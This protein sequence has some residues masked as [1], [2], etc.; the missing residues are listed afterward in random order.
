[1]SEDDQALCERVLQRVVEHELTARLGP[2]APLSVGPEAGLPPLVLLAARTIT[3]E[4]LQRRIRFLR[5]VGWLA[6]P[7]TPLP[8]PSLPAQA[9]L[10]D[11]VAAVLVSPAVK[12]DPDL[13]ALGDAYDGPDDGEIRR[14]D[15]FFDRVAD[16]VDPA[17]RQHVPGPPATSPAWSRLEA[18][19]MDADRWFGHRRTGRLWSSVASAAGW[20]GE[21]KRQRWR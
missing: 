10:E 9:S 15:A 19:T 11:R 12:S 2:S 5:I 6:E 3:P 13:I 20:L 18:A 16:A 14:L 21:E 17:W 8:E 7:P 4:V 1:M